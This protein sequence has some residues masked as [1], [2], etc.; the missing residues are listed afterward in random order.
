MSTLVSEI[1]LEVAREEATI[2][3]MDALEELIAAK[4]FDIDNDKRITKEMMEVRSKLKEGTLA[5]DLDRLVDQK[6]SVAVIEQEI[7]NDLSECL[8]HLQNMLEDARDRAARAAQALE[9]LQ[10]P[11]TRSS[12]PY[13]WTDIEEMELVLQ[14]AAES[15]GGTEQRIRELSQR[16]DD[17]LVNRAVVLGD[18]APTGLAKTARRAAARDLQKKFMNVPN[19]LQKFLSLNF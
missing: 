4:E 3:L 2:Q 5:V 16:I 11:E 13:E 19:A 10:R 9:G 1:E 7:V 12:S 8:I 18:D 14:Q 17:A 6:L 15:V